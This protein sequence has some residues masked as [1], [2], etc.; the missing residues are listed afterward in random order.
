[1]IGIRRIDTDGEISH[2]ERPK[3]VATLTE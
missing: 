2:I 1:L 3:I